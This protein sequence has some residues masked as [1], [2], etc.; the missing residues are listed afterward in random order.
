[1]IIEENEVFYS[2]L[3]EN[4]LIN[5]DKRIKLKEHYLI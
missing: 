1:M 3:Y 4:V 2:D 5:I